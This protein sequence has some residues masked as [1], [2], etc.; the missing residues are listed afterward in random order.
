[1]VSG[2]QRRRLCRFR[3]VPTTP[4]STSTF[5]TRAVRVRHRRPRRSVRRVESR[6]FP[7]APECPSAL[8]FEDRRCKPRRPESRPPKQSAF[9]KAVAKLSIRLF[10]RAP[11]SRP[12]R[13]PFVGH[14]STSIIPARRCAASL[15]FRMAIRMSMLPSSSSCSH[16]HSLTRRVDQRLHSRAMTA[17]GRRTDP[18]AIALAGSDTTFTLSRWRGGWCLLGDIS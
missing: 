6:A 18:D 2:Q 1:M 10:A 16:A 9:A 15:R 13:P 12:T 14:P 5:R 4:S 3:L 17:S 11:R 8:G 7:A